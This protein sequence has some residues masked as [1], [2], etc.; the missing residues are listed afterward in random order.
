MIQDV[1]LPIQS[2]GISRDEIFIVNFDGF[3]KNTSEGIVRAMLR[4][5]EIW[6]EKYPS[7]EMFRGM[8]GD[9]LYDSTMLTM[10]IDLLYELSDEKLTLD[11]IQ[12]D[13]KL[14]LPSIIVSTSRITM[15]EFALHQLLQEK[16]I[17][18]CYIFRDIGFFQNEINYINQMYT[19]VI[20]KI[21]LIGG[22][23][24]TAFNKYKPTTS[25][26]TDYFVVSD[27]IVPS[28]S[29]EDL[30]KKLF[31]IL[32]TFYNVQFDKESER[33]SYTEEFANLMDEYVKTNSFGM[34]AMYNFQLNSDEAENRLEMERTGKPIYLPSAEEVDEIIRKLEGEE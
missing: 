34:T 9:E 6:L 12:K 3:I 10:P 30:D 5:E 4:D 24:I 16:N 20:H 1:G 11:E 18:K 32:N 13:L 33:Y 31:I 7:L 29:K 27:Y 15:F 21:E 22:G 17:T 8:S 14:I 23:F 26:I 2:P 25:F 28:T 19:D